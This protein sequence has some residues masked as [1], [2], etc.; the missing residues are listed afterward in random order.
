VSAATVTVLVPAAVLLGTA[1][2]RPADWPDWPVLLQ[3]GA[4]GLLLR[5]SRPRL[6]KPDVPQQGADAD[7]IRALARHLFD[8]YGTN[9]V[10]YFALTEDKALWADPQ[11]RGAVAFQ[12]VGATALVVGDPLARPADLPDVLGRFLT[13]CR[14]RGW[15]P[16]FYQTLGTT[17][18]T[19]RAHG[20]HAFAIGREAL[21]DLPT[22]TLRGKAIANVRHS[23]THAERAGLTVR[24]Y[25]AA[26]LDG[27][28]RAALS[29]ISAE[30]LAAKRGAEMGF[31]MGRLSPEGWPSPRARVAMAYG[32]HGAAQAFLTVVP[33]GGARGWTLDL[34]RRRLEA[35]SGT[36]DLLIA[37]TAE[38][39][40]DEGF[41]TL[42]LSLAPLASSPGDDEDAPALARRARTL[43]YER[44]HGTYNYR[45]LFNYKKKFNVRWETRYLVYAGATRLPAAL[46]ATARAHLPRTLLPPARR[47]GSGG[48]A[49]RHQAA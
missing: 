21:I 40:R 3:A 28:T 17:L 42:S 24:L 23:V 39:L 30:W 41:A 27:V 15:R 18:A 26:E 1:V 34:M 8:E 2:L 46:Y 20:F 33:A 4:G 19:Y 31:T 16:A 29:A 32:A 48:A 22:F 38:A 45:S 6:S 7:G 5:R 9:G 25:E 36:M 35:V 37:R 10:G 11:G 14:A 44:M 43:L 47:C 49:A 13:H 12:L